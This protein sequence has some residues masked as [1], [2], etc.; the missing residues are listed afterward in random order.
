MQEPI[1]YRHLISAYQLFRTL[2]KSYHSPPGRST[3]FQHSVP[4][5]VGKLHAHRIVVRWK[6]AKNLLS[7]PLLFSLQALYIVCRRKMLFLLSVVIAFSMCYAWWVVV[8][9]LVFLS[10]VRL[11]IWHDLAKQ[12]L[13]IYRRFSDGTKAFILLNLSALSCTNVYILCMRPGFVSR[14]LFI[15]S[16]TDK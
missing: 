8:C 12:T 10:E 1:T 14:I 7:H 3:V 16:V 4:F 9:L 5:P 2:T 13:E 6:G 15:I 11:V